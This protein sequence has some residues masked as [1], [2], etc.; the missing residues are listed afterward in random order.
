MLEINVLTIKF[1][2]MCVEFHGSSEV[3]YVEVLLYLTYNIDFTTS[4]IQS[5]ENTSENIF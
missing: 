5:L 2:F 4:M 1:I 3:I